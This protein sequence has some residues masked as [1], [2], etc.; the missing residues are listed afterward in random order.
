VKIFNKTLKPEE[1]I[2]FLKENPDFFIEHPDAIESLEIKHESGE[3]VS[4]IEKQVELI[5]AKNLETSTKL[6]E[7]IIN[8]KEN[9]ILFIK[10]KKLISVILN[11][12][13]LEKLLNSTED[14]FEK[15]LGSEK[16][17]IFF[18]TQDDL[19]EV[20]DERVIQ[21]EI[22]TPAFSSIFK[23][24][25]IYLGGISNEV[26]SLTFGAKSSVKESAI[27]KLNSKE[28]AGI[29]ILGSS[30]QKK[31]TSGQDTLFLNF[32]LEVLS[33]QIDKLIEVRN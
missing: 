7:F 25:N 4:F 12:K 31:Y 26:A 19:F 20:S 29:L 24:K 14:F 23:D 21:P 32:V 18:F 27:C 9:E 33:H 6:K 16:C 10:I 22:A 3:A 2:I 17:K 30:S 5:K 1:V 28:V 11:S 13:D 15:E 8:A